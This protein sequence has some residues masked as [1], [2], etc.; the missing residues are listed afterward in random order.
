[1]FKKLMS[2][3][4]WPHDT[5]VFLLSW[6]ISVKEKNCVSRN[7]ELLISLSK[8]NF[9]YYFK[10]PLTEYIKYKFRNYNWKAYHARIQNDSENR[11]KN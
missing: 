7:S 6:V 10:L 3:Y 9:Y 5:Y 8:K 11:L 2:I 1:M 4:E